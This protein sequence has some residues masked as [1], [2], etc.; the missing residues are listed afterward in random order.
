MRAETLHLPIK[1]PG[2]TDGLAIGLVGGS[3]DPPHSGHLHLIETARK[4]L[5]LDAVWVIPS[6]GNPLKSTQTP[7]SQRLAAAK[8]LLGGPR[9]RVSDIEAQ[10]G[11][12]YSIDLVKALKRRAPR[13]RFVWIMGADSLASF[14][15]WKDWRTL[16]RTLPV[17]VVSRPGASPKA[18][19]SR[20]ALM[21]AG[22]RI[23][24]GLARTLSN[25]SAPAWTLLN[26]PYDATSSTALRGR[27]TDAAKTRPTASA[28][29][30]ATS[31]PPPSAPPPG[32]SGGKPG[33]P[34]GGG[35]FGWLK[36]AFGGSRKASPA[37]P[38]PR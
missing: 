26:A 7:F 5:G 20:F 30:A 27:T 22:S 19:T 6:P 8:A 4:A 14:D 2:P 16:A 21:F 33:K 3:F 12:R 28:K 24:P 17:C 37:Q 18:G 38:A 34:S 25:R 32:V 35:L 29:P 9:V 23:A 13:A 36:R 10:L 31:V 11:T 1:L 15:Q